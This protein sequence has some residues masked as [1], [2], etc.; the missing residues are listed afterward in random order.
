MLPVAAVLP[1][2]VRQLAAAPQLLLHAPPGAGKT[3]VVP[4]ALLAAPQFAG[5][6]LLMLEPRRLAA[7]AAAQRLAFLLNEEVGGTVGYTTR[8]D[9]C[10]SSRT[11]LELVTEGILARRLQRDPSLD[12]NGLVIF[13]EFHER[14][15]QTDLS[16]ALT[17]DV[18][19]HLRPDLR[20]LIM[21][22]TLAVERLQAL[23]P[24][25]AALGC[26]GRL[27][28]VDVRYLPATPEGDPAAYTAAA[29]RRALH[30]HDG[31]ILAFL[32]GSGEISRAQELLAD[33]GCDLVPLYGDLPREAQ[34][35]ALH[36]GTR[37]RVVLAT[38][39]AET[40]ITV[41]NISVVID[42][43]WMRQPEYDA[44]RDMTRLVTVRVS[45]ANAEQRAGRAGRLA[46]G[47]CYRLWSTGTHHA[48]LDHPVPEILQ[49]DL[50][51]LALDLALWGAEPGALTWLDL[52]PPGAYARARQILHLLGALDA[53]GRLTNSGRAMATLPVHPRLAALLLQAKAQ[54]CG[55][56]GCD[57]AAL[58]AERDIRC[59][60][61]DRD[62]D[63]SARL[64]ALHAFRRNRLPR[65]Y[66][67]S[68]VQR[69]DRLAVQWRDLLQVPPS[70]TVDERMVGCL[71]AQAYPD[72]I[73]KRR[74]TADERFLLAGGRGARLRGG[75]TLRHA[76]WLVVAD[77]DAG[78]TD[79]MIRL[80]AAFD[81]SLLTTRL[82]QL[83]RTEE[84]CAWDARAEA[85]VAVRTVQCGA[86]TMS[87]T[88]LPAPSAEVAATAVLDGIRRLGLACL[89][90]DEDTR[91][92][93]ARVLSLRAWLGEVW[94]DV[95]DVALLATL[96]QWLLPYLTGITRRAQFARL[97]LMAALHGLLDRTQ[98]QQFAR[99]APTHLTVPSGARHRLAYHPDGAP[100][101]LAVKLQEMFGC[102]TTPRVANDTI[103]V[104]LHLLSPARRPLQVTD[105]LA[106]FWART[107]A[108]VRREL[109]GRY[110]KHPWPDDPLAAL[111]TA[112]T[113]K[114]VQRRKCT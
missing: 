82:A 83:L 77:L 3:T 36:A 37:R 80:A 12:G 102:R 52:P 85:V 75:D 17:L 11:R 99:L 90:W 60:A 108:E 56:L 110:P 64:A 16:V 92:W 41:E 74:G 38:P 21:S 73:A 100:P 91:Q 29:V 42:S 34:D 79:G 86:I 104:R 66:D 78:T 87:E 5:Q 88:A 30:D 45:R 113:K 105:D 32:P 14:H 107:Y 18:Q 67:R 8:L 114:Q 4:L 7:R 98:Q 109:R 59:R 13:D 58:L 61:D 51:P 2:L 65:G 71:L 35:R 101:V 94:P 81:E 46:P 40:S 57:I 20:L 1:E 22:A 62:A 6:R 76:D 31:D 84:Q 19:R 112:K 49:A 50:T 69:V 43:G 33:A 70:G 96:E 106:G 63:F 48:L 23:L 53:G 89:P 25:A 97:D 111:P 54:Q 15:L 10:V 26:D 95:S 27:F 44:A 47:T 55:G 68:A 93:Q 28:P 103:G 39:L 24:Q 9:R 72:R